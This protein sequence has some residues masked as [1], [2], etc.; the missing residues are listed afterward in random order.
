MISKS[1]KFSLL[2]SLLLSSSLYCADGFD[3]E[4]EFSSDEIVI[5]KVQQ[6]EKKDFIYFGSITTG[7]EYSYSHQGRL[8][9]A[10]ISGNLNLEYKINDKFKA[11]ST[12]KAYNDFNSEVSNDRAFDINE[13]YVQGSI[14]TNIDLKI[15]RQI[16]VWGKSDNI[17]IT[18]TLNPMDITKPGMVD[19]KDLRLGRFMAKLDYFTPI[20]SYN[21]ILLLENR[22]STL[23]DKKSEYFM[24]PTINEPANTLEN[25]GIAFSAN[26]NF[27][28]QDISVYLSNQYIDNTTYKSNM[29]GL[30][31]NKVINSYLIKAEVAVFD[32]YD[33]N[34]IKSKIDSLIGLEYSGINEGSLSLEIA[35]K[36]NTIQYAVRFT[37]SYINQTINFTT[38]VSAYGKKFEDG[39]FI[40]V[41]VDYDYSDKI[42]LSAGIIDYKGGNNLYFEKIKNN[43]RIFTSL[44][45]SF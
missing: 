28:G 34:T 1:I 23:A 9:S 7:A 8:S 16:V 18:D 42:S 2:T 20:W 37:Q 21:A 29:L 38:L 14:D 10:K 19:I 13:L 5:Q 35:N 12:I 43:D 32:N 26:A 36:D 3:E 15:G 44:K 6:E 22:Y 40:R 30:A 27:E 31:Y 11:K 41:W 39:G 45:Y 24:R 4:D 17:R 33:S 25:S